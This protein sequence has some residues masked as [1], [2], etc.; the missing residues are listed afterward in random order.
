MTHLSLRSEA[1]LTP[2]QVRS[3]FVREPDAPPPAPS[4]PSSFRAVL[5]KL[6]REVDRGEAVVNRA[7]RANPF[8]DDSRGMIALQAGVYR[9]VEAI[10]LLS[11]LVDRAAS[12]VK[13][14]LQ[15]Q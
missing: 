15:N 13:T 10:D 6:G 8:A 5:H 1:R 7:L 4:E 9:Y 12:A 11:R 14:T 2:P 3:E